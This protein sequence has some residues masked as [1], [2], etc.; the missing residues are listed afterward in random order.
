MAKKKTTGTSAEHSASKP[1][2][3]D[4]TG[5]NSK[6][7]VASALA[8][9][10]SP[11]KHTSSETASAASKTLRDGRTS[12]DSKASAGSALSQRQ[13]TQR[14]NRITSLGL[15]RDETDARFF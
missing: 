15:S 6:T 10:H 9:S 2:Q 1:L 4:H 3:G 12:K 8:Q 7:V 14:R 11:K 5:K 13:R